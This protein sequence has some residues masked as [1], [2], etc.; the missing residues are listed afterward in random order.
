[1][2]V[3][4]APITDADTAAVAD[5]LHVNFDERV[6][7]ARSYMALPW[8]VDAPN[9]GFML[10]DDQRIVGAYLAFY[11][12]RLIAGQVERF[13]NLGAWCVLPEYRFHSVRLL[14]ALL[15]Q[16]GYHFTDMSPNERV[17]SVNA[18]FKFRHLDTSAV[19]V[20]HLPWPTL[21]GRTKISADP[22]VITDTLAGPDLEL[23]RDHAQ[24]PAA[25]HLMLIRGSES[26]YVMYREVRHRNVPV[27]AVILYVSNPGLFRRALISL[28]RYLLVRRRLLGT[29]AE[30]RT[31]RYQPY[32]S[33]RLNSW[34]KMY[35]SA[36]LEP[37][38]IDDLY[39][40]LVCV[41]W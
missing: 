14:K 16:D 41:P 31:V 18:R 23:Y 38:Q 33:F 4:L 6:P 17:E 39:S 27:L 1:M 15:T 35:R 8:K 36:T 28:T 19:F 40:E 11:S 34:P 3:K 12:E 29:L 9:H 32:F 10:R 37:G 20:P 30:L 5:F 26:C 7:W 21:P 13:C 25:H 22:D 2:I 24:A